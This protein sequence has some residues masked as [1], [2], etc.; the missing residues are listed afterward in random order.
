MILSADVAVLVAAV[1]GCAAP[2]AWGFAGTATYAGAATCHSSIDF[3]HFLFNLVS[4]CADTGT[5]HFRRWREIRKGCKA[6]SDKIGQDCPHS[7][8]RFHGGGELG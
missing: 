1:A 7:C 5:G 6:A 4:C 3:A 8:K 2:G